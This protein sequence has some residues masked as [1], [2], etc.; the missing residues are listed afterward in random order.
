[1]KKIKWFLLLFFAC[2]VL[3]ACFHQTTD[4][5]MLTR[6]EFKQ[7]LAQ[8]YTHYLACQQTCK[9]NCPTCQRQAWEQAADGYKRYAH[10]IKVAGDYNVR[11][12]KSYRDPLQ[13]RKTTCNCRADL[14]ACRQAC[15]GT[16]Y[17]VL[18]AAPY[19]T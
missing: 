14:I 6:T 10:Q 12:L 9:N 2:T 7:C 5:S 17:K 1:M 13:C 15:S 19:C 3:T 11:Q 4:K 18:R 8:C 16:V